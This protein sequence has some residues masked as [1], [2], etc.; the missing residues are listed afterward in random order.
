M[1]IN[2]PLLFYFGIT[3]ALLFTIIYSIF[4]RVNALFDSHFFNLSLNFS[5]TF[6]LHFMEK[7]LLYI[8]LRYQILKHS[9]IHLLPTGITS[10]LF[11]IKYV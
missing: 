7:I 3:V 11:F 5:M 9:C 2:D 10:E 1:F 8:L 4:R 6:C